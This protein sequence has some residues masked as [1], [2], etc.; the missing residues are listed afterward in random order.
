[1]PNKSRSLVTMTK[2]SSTRR[3]EKT[4]HELGVKG[5]SVKKWSAGS[6][7]K[8]ISYIHVGD[9]GRE[10]L[11]RYMTTTT[12]LSLQVYQEESLPDLDEASV[13]NGLDQVGTCTD[14]SDELHQCTRACPVGCQGHLRP[15]EITIY[16][17]VSLKGMLV[18]RKR[19]KARFVLQDRPRKISKV[20]RRVSD[21]VSEV[22]EPI[23]EKY[24]SI[25]DKAHLNAESQ[26]LTERGWNPEDKSCNLAMKSHNHL[27][28][29]RQPV[30]QSTDAVRSKVATSRGICIYEMTWV[31]KMRGTHA[32]VGVA[33]SQAPLH[34]PG[35][36]SLI[37]CNSNSWGWDI[38]RKEAKHDSNSTNYPPTVQNHYE[39]TVPDTFL[40]IID[41]D[42]GTVSFA[43]D[44]RWYGTAF[45]NLQGKRVFPAVSTVWGHAEVTI[46]YIGSS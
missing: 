20:K 9:G 18:E 27:C 7:P 16:E 1:M 25:I 45:D 19:Y 28:V 43:G 3:F 31:A 13:I 30:T 34:S 15:N 38:G 40:M 6:S 41:M 12:N 5:G 23:P 26:T 2:N 46:R 17:G 32:S 14:F 37:G 22:G 39:W 8:V 24:Q 29:R 35:Y 36:I 11:E 4:K 21:K 44:G 10:D 33:T 42:E